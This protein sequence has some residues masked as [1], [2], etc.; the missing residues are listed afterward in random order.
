MF[1]TPEPLSLARGSP[2]LY[3]EVPSAAG[4]PLSEVLRAPLV[5]GQWLPRVDRSGPALDGMDR[6][7][8]RHPCG[9]EGWV[10]WSTLGQ[11][12]LVD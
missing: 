2:T 4:L 3:K 10:F 8:A 9:R 12:I 11:V 6:G 5:P 7:F 1:L